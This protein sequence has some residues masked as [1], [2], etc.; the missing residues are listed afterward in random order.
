MA[1]IP[2]CKALFYEFEAFFKQ[3]MGEFICRKSIENTE[4]EN[5]GEETPKESFVHTEEENC[6]QHSPKRLKE[7]TT[8]KES[9]TMETPKLNEKPLPLIL[10]PYVGSPLAH[11]RRAKRRW[12]DF[13]VEESD[14][15]EDVQ[16]IIHERSNKYNVKRLRL[17]EE[18]E[19]YIVL[20]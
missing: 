14:E 9:E 11:E 19:E 8:V 1:D 6:G 18:E 2:N 7:V 13:D 3:K 4:E 10:I 20:D 5:L 17:E 15:G 16:E 12:L